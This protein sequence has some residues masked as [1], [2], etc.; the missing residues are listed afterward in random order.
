M[1]SKRQKVI[2][3]QATDAVELEKQLEFNI[4]WII[5]EYN[6]NIYNNYYN[7]LLSKKSN[8]Q[9]VKLLNNKFNISIFIQRDYSLIN[10]DDALVWLG[11]GHPYRWI[12]F[13][14]IK[15]INRSKNPYL[16]VQN[17]IDNYNLG[18]TISKHYMKKTNL[19]YIKRNINIFRGIYSHVDSQTGGPFALYMLDNIDADEVILVASIIN[20]PGNKKINHLLE[21]DALIGNI[22]FQE[23][24]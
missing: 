9:L 8:D 10:E 14:K 6:Q 19:S 1:F 4:S 3:L 17:I 2:L 13:Y 16:I 18:I 7:Y 12:V 11:R 20:N 15:N 5:S 22:K 24:E 21:M 23:I